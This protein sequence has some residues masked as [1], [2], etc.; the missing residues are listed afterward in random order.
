MTRFWAVFAAGLM[1]LA[2]LATACF[3]S[4]SEPEL[5]GRGLLGGTD[6]DKLSVP[7]EDIHVDTFVS[8]S[9][10]L[11]EIEE[12]ALLGLRD[13][14]PPIDNP[15]YTMMGEAAWLNAGDLV[16]GYVADD[17]QAYAY[18][19]RILDQHEIVNDELGG[20]SVL[21]S[22]C[23]LCR[24]GIVY[25]RV[26]EDGQLLSFGNTSALYESD[27]VM[28]DR[29]TLSYWF[30]VGGE[31]IVGDLTGA[32]LVALPSV[33]ST[34]EQWQ[35]LHPDTLVLSRDLGFARNY[36]RNITLGLEDVINGGRFPFPVTDAA[37]D[38]RLEPAA[39]VLGVEFGDDRRAYSLE[40]LGDVAIN[41]TL[42]GERIAVFSK[43]E[44]PIAAAFLVEADGQ[45]LT[46]EYRD[47]AFVDEET[48]SAWS[49]TGEA[50]SGELAGSQLEPLAV[51]TAFW[52]SYV[53]AFPGVD[54]YEP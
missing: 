21:I 28:Y 34:W 8:G 48:G 4:D 33:T 24:S 17:G 25:D 39:L 31:A 2:L 35:K 51:R 41:D 11:S 1:A 15:K 27:L 42:G 14:I 40:Q 44:G 7:L 20:K 12:V 49:L 26:L 29:E 22:F 46:F 16:L 54:L 6:T 43:S 53:S 9:I 38:D 37:K 50:L 45:G 3:G 36:D 32:R 13:A 18:P 19:A 5:V 23:P 10:P 30:Q 52:F 47:G